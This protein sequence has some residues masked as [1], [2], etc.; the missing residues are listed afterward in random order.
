MMTLNFLSIDVG[1]RNL[2]YCTMA[3]REDGTA[4]I[5]KWGVVC[6]GDQGRATPMRSMA[7]AIVTNFD[8]LFQ[9][10]AY[11]AV[12]IENQPSVMAPTMK[13]LQMVIYAYFVMQQPASEI[14]LVPASQ[15]LSVS[16]NTVAKKDVT[17]AKNY[18][19]RKKLAI[20]VARLYLSA[21]WRQTFDA[22]KKK[23]D[24]ADALLQ[25]VSWIERHHP[26]PH[27]LVFI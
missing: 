18:A 24:L 19:V 25:G 17:G 14:H 15:K 23:D 3:V 4:S 12:L 11:D 20:E 10:V 21:E 5:E 8:E 22:S 6:V 7:D 26:R 16:K 1:I 27:A 2:A 9:G 13:S